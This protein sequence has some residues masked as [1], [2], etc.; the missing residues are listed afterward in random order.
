MRW[1]GG[2]VYNVLGKIGCGAFAT[3]YKLVTVS[4]GNEYAAKEIEKRRFIKNGVLDRKIATELKII[5]NLN[6]VSIC[7]YAL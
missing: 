3:V 6:H 7:P 1:N 2:G 4:D 5:E